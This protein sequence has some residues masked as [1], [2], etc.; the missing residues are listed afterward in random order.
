ML[1]LDRSWFNRV[2]HTQ[3]SRTRCVK[4]HFA[5]HERAQ[6]LVLL[7]VSRVVGHIS[8]GVSGPNV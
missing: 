4:T 6:A 3:V 8:P 1:Y 7:E 5:D 2:H